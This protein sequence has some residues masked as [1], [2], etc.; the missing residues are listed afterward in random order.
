MYTM[1]LVGG[2]IS[3][4]CVSSAATETDI[5]VMLSSCLFRLL[6]RLELFTSSIPRSISKLELLPAGSS[7]ELLIKMNLGACTCT[8][9]INAVRFT[10]R[11]SLTCS[12]K[13]SKLARVVSPSCSKSK[14]DLVPLGGLQNLTLETRA[15]PTPST[16]TSSPASSSTSES[17]FSFLDNRK[18]R[19]A[20]MSSSSFSILCSLMRL[21]SS[22]TDETQLLPSCSKKTDLSFSGVLLLSSK[23]FLLPPRISKCC[24][25]RAKSNRELSKLSNARERSRKAITDIDCSR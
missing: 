23:A 9:N 22:E 6:S 12:R 14:P 19:I 25:Y 3:S 8:S 24:R 21:N 18:I 13:Y 10:N 11:D 7:S 4:D 2:K 15:P 20:P 1:K 5:R 17:S 16:P